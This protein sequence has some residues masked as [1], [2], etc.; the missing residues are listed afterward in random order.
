MYANIRGLHANLNDLIAASRQYD[1]LLCSET[2][3]SGMRHASEVLIPGFKKPILFKR[4]AIHRA[5]G[6]AAYVRKDFPAS[7]KT[8]YE[9]RCHEVQVFKVC[10]KTN[11]FYLFSVYRNPDADDTIFDCLFTSMAA[12]QVSDRKAAFLFEMEVYYS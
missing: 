5:Q 12:I 9:C 3:V 7:H 1:I 10:G 11:N 8:N 4:N 2:L 6:M